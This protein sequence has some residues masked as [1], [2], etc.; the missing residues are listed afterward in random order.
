M[1]SYAGPCSHQQRRSGGN[2]KLKG[3]LDCR[4]LEKIFRAARS[5]LSWTSGDQGFSS[6]VVCLGEYH[7]NNARREERPRKLINMQEFSPP[8]SIAMYPHE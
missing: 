7:E 4:D 5:S 8:G 6:S 2:V 1:R 3:S